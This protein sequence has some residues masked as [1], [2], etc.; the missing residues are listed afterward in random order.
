MLQDRISKS[1]REHTAVLEETFLLQANEL[2]EFSGRIVEVFN[3]GGRLLIFGSGSLGAIA[4]LVANLFRHRLSFERPPLPALSLCHDI[5]LATAL[6]KEG[7]ICA[8]FAQQIGLLAGE[9]DAVLALGDVAHNEAV[10]AGLAEARE[11]GCVTAALLPDQKEPS[12]DGPH[13]LFRLN[14]DSV[15]RAAEAALFFGHLLCELVEESLFGS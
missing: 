6:A 11:R 8:F 10:M 12:G 1:L 9:H 7:Q 2:V 4:N 15:G 14:T 5:T 3:Q 13:Y